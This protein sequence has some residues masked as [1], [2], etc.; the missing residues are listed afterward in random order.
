[1]FAT[2][3]VIS[4][5]HLTHGRHVPSPKLAKVV[6]KRLYL[7]VSFSQLH[8]SN[9]KVRGRENLSTFSQS[10]SI[11]SGNTSMCYLL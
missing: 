10:A 11:E 6:L 2:N 4:D 1:M 5:E 7:P 9:Y 8:R 3:F